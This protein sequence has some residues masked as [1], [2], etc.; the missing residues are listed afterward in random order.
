MKA[1]GRSL[2]VA[3]SAKTRA[4]PRVAYQRVSAA[5]LSLPE[6]WFR[7]AIFDD[8]ELVIGPCREA[9]R[10][11]ADERW[12]PWETEFN[13]GAGP[14]DVLLISSHGRPAIIETKLSYNPEK[15]REVIAQILDYALSLQEAPY[16]DLPKL[17]TSEDAPDAAD[18]HDCLSAGRFLLVV[19]GD[20]LDPR[21]LRL[22]EAL[23]ARHLTTEWDLAMVDLN[24]YRSTSPDDQLLLVPE[25]RGVVLAETRQV[26]RVQVEGETPRARVLVE[27]LP[28]DDISATRRPK[29]NSVDDFY[30]GVHKR[31]PGAEGAIRRIVERFQQIDGASQGRF[32]L[33]LQTASA[34]LYWKPGTGALRRIFAMME[35]GRFR[36]WLAYVLN[37][38]REDV[39]TAIRELSKPVVAIA[40]GESTGA[41]FV[42]Q[43]NVDAILS[44]IDA[45]VAAVAQMEP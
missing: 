36:V 32:V 12:L 6:S 19:A 29:L 2:F 41:L 35:S 4:S 39:A 18:L 27:R 38:G 45:V 43:N 15:R 33:A 34:N 9:G 26:V 10:V 11:P 1:L 5:D 31:S 17:P 37:E 28:A 20:A 13:F 25:L 14:V 7:D 3:T 8:P 44:V 22:S 16:D 40:P 23:L 42:D 24:V 21:A 30:A